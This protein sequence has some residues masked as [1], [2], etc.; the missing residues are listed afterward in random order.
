MR[1]VPVLLFTCA[2]LALVFISPVT[3]QS[4]LEPNVARTM[5][6]LLGE[7]SV[8]YMASLT[9]GQWTVIVTS[10]AFWG[11]QVRIDVATDSSFTDI[12]AENGLTAG[13]FP[14]I[15]F[16]L[17][18]DATVYIRLEENSVYGDTSGF[19][20][21]GVY[22]EGHVLGA[23]VGSFL[24]ANWMILLFTVPF[25]FII[26]PCIFA[27]RRGRGPG[28]QQYYR[29][30]RSFTI[31]A[32]PFAIPDEHRGS[33]RADGSDLTTVRVPSKCPNC[34]AALSQSTLE[35]TGPLEARCNYC[36]A[37]IHATF[38]RI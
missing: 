19:Y 6:H 31:S 10:D 30:R 4:N 26:F 20:D 34:S 24:S 11:L 8:T 13:N 14:E 15:G 23:R 5:E 38:E 25:I 18:S 33:T 27:A 29:R 2:L 32:P 16:D 37:T 1:R 21:I 17:L 28:A 22:D 35:W 9:A 36:G 7:E 12:I 3:A